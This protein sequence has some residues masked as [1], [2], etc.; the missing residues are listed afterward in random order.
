MGSRWSAVV[1]DAFDPARLGMWWAE[2]LGYRVL[3]ENSDEAQIGHEAGAAP[4]LVFVRAP[5]SK[6]GRNRLRIDLTPDNQEAEVERLVDMGARRV[7][8]GHSPDG[9]WEVLVDPEGNEFCVL[10]AGSA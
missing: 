4:T 8:L 2:V 1:V 7:D 10:R 3:H 9:D 6:A 5:E